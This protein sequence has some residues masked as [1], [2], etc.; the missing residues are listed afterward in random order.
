MDLDVR[1]AEH[2]IHERRRAAPDRLQA[3]E[4]RAQIGLLRRHLVGR[5]Q[6]ERLDPRQQVH[7]VPEPLDEVLEEVVVRVDQSRHG[8]HP[9]GVD[10]LG[11]GSAREL[12]DRADPANSLPDD[13]DRGALDDV[14][15]LVAQPSED[16]SRVGDEEVEG[17][18]A[19]HHGAV[20]GR[21]VRHVVSTAQALLPGP[22]GACSSLISP[23]PRSI[24][25]R[26]TILTYGFR[27]MESATDPCAEVTTSAS[28]SW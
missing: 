19:A 21:G 18:L 14:V 25:K 7:L 16:S 28:R 10:R 23:P 24:A 8:Q 13:A 2:E 22:I 26:R 20:G 6:D 15:L 9:A 4:H 5:R 3:P 17:M 1:N 11:P 27:C 12:R